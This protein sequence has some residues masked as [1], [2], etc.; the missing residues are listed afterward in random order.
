MKESLVD[1]LIWQHAQEGLN[2]IDDR[3]RFQYTCRYQPVSQ[4]FALVHL[5]E[6]LVRFFPEIDKE[7]GR[8]GA[9]SIK[10]AAD[11][12]RESQSSFPI[13]EVFM[14]ML[15]ET[16]RRSL[17]PLPDELKDIF[18]RPRRKS[19]F[20]LDDAI[21]ACTNP[22]YLQPVE[23]IQKRLSPDFANIWMTHAALGNPRIPCGTSMSRQ[24][25]LEE[26]GARDLLRILNLSKTR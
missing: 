14:A 1:P 10:L 15:H 4:I 11:I 7:F 22:T 20:L 17:I 23:A 16:T 3:Y 18:R 21:N 9:T 13:A 8:D 24:P 5:T 25:S 19:R 6:V 2:L 12:L 26:R